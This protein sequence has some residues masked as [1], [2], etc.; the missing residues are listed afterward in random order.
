MAGVQISNIATKQDLMCGANHLNVAYV[1]SN[2]YTV[3]GMIECAGAWYRFVDEPVTVT[4]SDYIKMIPVIGATPGT[5]TAT[6][7]A[8]TSFS[9]VAFDTDKNGYYVTATNERVFGYRDSSTKCY[10]LNNENNVFTNIIVLNETKLKPIIYSTYGAVDG[11]SLISE[12]TENGWFD[13]LIQYLPNDG[14]M[15]SCFGTLVK[16]ANTVQIVGIYRVNFSLIRAYGYIPS[17]S[18]VIN[19]GDGDS[20]AIQGILSII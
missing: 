6:L 17:S 8:I 1:S 12:A 16:G 14:D 20:T 18:P 10:I 15:R 3:S 13:T 5:N 4:T 11:T 7:A 9:G 2:D 19:I